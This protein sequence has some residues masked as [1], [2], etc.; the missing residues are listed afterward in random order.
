MIFIKIFLCPFSM[1]AWR[2]GYNVSIRDANE[3]PYPCKP[4]YLSPPPGSCDT[5]FR[6]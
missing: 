3:S 5:I 4:Y 1:S 2:A 6:I